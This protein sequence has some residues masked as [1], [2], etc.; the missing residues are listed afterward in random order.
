MVVCMYVCMYVCVHLCMHVS[1]C[2]YICMSLYVFISMNFFFIIQRVKAR[3]IP[4]S[5]RPPSRGDNTVSVAQGSTATLGATKQLLPPDRVL[6]ESYVYIYIYTP[7]QLN[8]E[9]ILDV[10]LHFLSAVCDLKNAFTFSGWCYYAFTLTVSYVIKRERWFRVYYLRAENVLA[11]DQIQLDAYR[12]VVWRRFEATFKLRPVIPIFE[13]NE[14]TECPIKPRQPTSI[15]ITWHI[16]PF[17]T[18][19]ARSDS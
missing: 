1:A 18:Q 6:R 8:A 15:G 19:S 3:A 13:R 5:H 14:M 16:Q 12:A 7:D 10:N 4:C 11:F 17:S 9:T 2:M